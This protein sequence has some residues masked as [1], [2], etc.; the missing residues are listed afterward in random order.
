MG[1]CGK[2]SAILQARQMVE[3]EIGF[4]GEVT[5]VGIVVTNN[6]ETSSKQRAA[7]TTSGTD[8]EQHTRRGWEQEQAEHTT[9]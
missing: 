3:K 6:E 2:D 9:R 4:V 1:L 5:K 8:N 7:R